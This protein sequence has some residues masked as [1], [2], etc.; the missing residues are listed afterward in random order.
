MARCSVNRR[1]CIFPLFPDQ[2][3][4][5]FVRDPA[6]FIHCLFGVK[7]DKTTPYGGGK[8]DGVA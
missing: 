5:S 1:Y 3:T 6:S 4:V 7:D 8:P 2:T